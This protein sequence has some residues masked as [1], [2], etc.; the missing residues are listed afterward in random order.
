[1]GKNRNRQNLKDADINIRPYIRDFS[2]TN[3]NTD[4][5][6]KL[7]LRG[8]EAARRVLPLLIRLRD[9]LQLVAK[10]R[11]DHTM[12][13]NDSVLIINNIEVTG[14]DR[15]QVD[16]YLGQV[17]VK[18]SQRVSMEH[19]RNGI[20]R[21][22]STG[23]YEYV[24]YQL[25]GNR[26]KTLK[27][28]VKERKNN[29]INAGLRYD[30][31]YKS[32]MLVNITLRNQN[33]FGSRLS[34]DAK[35]SEYPMF[36]AHYSLD[37]GWKPGFFTKVMYVEDR[38]NRYDGD[39][40]T[41]EIEKSLVNIQLAAHSFITDATRFS[42][43]TSMDS[44]HTGSII[45]DTTGYNIH[46]KTYFNL[47]SSIVHNSIN[48]TYFP[49]KGVRVGCDVKIILNSWPDDPVMVC[50]FMYSRARSLSDRIALRYGFDSRLVLGQNES[51]FHRTNVG[52][53]SQPDY[54]GNNIPFNGVKRMQFQTGSIG[55]G[56]LEARLRLWEKIYVSM[57]G[58]YGLYSEDNFFFTNQ[59]TIWGVGLNIAYDSVVG[60]MMINLSRSN[61][62]KELLPFLSL[63]F[64]F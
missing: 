41:A 22:Y 5:A 4:A 14:T 43:G 26:Y 44:Y 24:N 23:N 49:T 63:G 51:F 2:A 46:D 55:V 58:D 13:K 48:R 17:G 9:S 35:L 45:G 10:P 30:S 56:R 29:K 39:K 34:M 11:L 16:F 19:L 6:E 1:M 12:I 57:S 61:L 20:S 60:P 59:E 47:F 3:F 62:N 31:D 53:V 8:E 33:F 54:F 36:A 42:I 28:E 64:W 21:L 18:H 37:R 52:G 50:D 27:I 40:K 38:M 32:S 25:S 7:I 15:T